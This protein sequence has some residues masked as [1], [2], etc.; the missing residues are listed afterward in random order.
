MA[1]DVLDRIIDNVLDAVVTPNVTGRIGENATAVELWFSKL[2]GKKGIT[3]RNLYLPKEDGTTT[4]I[5][6]VYVTAKGIF[7]IESK[8]YSGWIFGS[9]KDAQWTVMLP[10]REKNRF[11]NP[12]WQNKGHIKWLEQYL[13]Q[14]IPMIS[15]IVFSQRCEL[16]KVS[17]QSAKTHV[18]KRD[19][20]F[21][22]LHCLWKELP[23][24]LS[25]AAVKQVVERL[26]PLTEAD[27]VKKAAHV[28][29]VQAV[30]QKA[31]MTCPKCGGQLVLRTA[32]KGENAGRQF[33]GCGNFPTCRYIRNI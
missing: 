10:N 20:L 17:V 15:L 31:T 9:E 22:T 14:E 32:K 6:L 4:E 3:L 23:D 33:Y 7:V 24:V 30:Q 8:N 13:Q 19:D 18:I 2:L 28:E 21:P 27:A 12:I 16:K 26:Q 25:E 5:D 1:K 11:Y 29:Q